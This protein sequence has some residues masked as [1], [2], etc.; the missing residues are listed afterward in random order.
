MEVGADVVTLAAAD[1]RSLDAWLNDHHRG[2]PTWLAELRRLAGER[3]A[4]WPLPQR[5]KSAL[6]AKRWEKAPVLAAPALDSLPHPDSLS[7]NLWMSAAGTVLGSLPPA[8]QSAGVLVWDLAAAVLQ[9]PELVRQ[10]LAR[11]LALDRQD[12]YG[13][14]E[15]DKFLALNTALWRHGAFIYVPPRVVVPEPIT[16]QYVLTGDALTLYPRTLVIA[17]RESRVTVVEHHLGGFE[18]SDNRRLVAGAVELFVAAGA[19]VEYSAVQDYGMETDVV[20]RR[21]AEVERDGQVQ[22]N[23]GE[24]GGG[25]SMARHESWLKE[26]GASAE[27]SVVFFGSQAQHQEF[28][29]HLE[30]LAPHTQSD[31]FARGVMAGRARSTFTGVTHIRKGASQSNGRQREETLMLSPQAR[32]DAVPSLLIDEHDVFAA[33]AAS[34]GPVEETTLHYLMSRGLAEEEAIAL[35]VHGFLA[36]VVDRLPEA[37][38]AVV[39]EHVERKMGQ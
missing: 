18:D 29:A 5:A 10:Y 27:S 4:A 33:H 21:Y 31:L 24:F 1:S 23:L 36:P 9:A 14:P 15:N 13:K 20:I 35:V 3:A 25:V 32:A 30:H 7:V 34:A 17:D 2:E 11:G 26:P 6:R 28:T 39:W 16:V 12:L 19:R 38:Q 8:W 37:I 22:W